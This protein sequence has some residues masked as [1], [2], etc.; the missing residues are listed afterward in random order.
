M[1]VRMMPTISLYELISA[2]NNQYNIEL[3]WLDMQ[4]DLDGEKC[5][6]DCYFTYDYGDIEEDIYCTPAIVCIRTFL[7]DTIPNYKKV[8]IRV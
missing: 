8:L 5:N 3:N 1:K 4:Y 6:E 2:V 7:R